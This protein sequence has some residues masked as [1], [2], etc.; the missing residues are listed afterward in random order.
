M[1]ILMAGRKI[2]AG[3]ERDYHAIK[4]WMDENM[5]TGSQVARDV[6]VALVNCSQ[7]IRGLSNNRKILR[8]L[9]ELG[10]PEDILSLPKDMKAT[11]PDA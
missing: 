11:P 8:R 9:L 7:V 6:G 3:R 4:R 1:L 2:G 10:C 5:V